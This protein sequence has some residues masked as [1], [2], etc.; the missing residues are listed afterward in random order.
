[1]FD[2]LR[3]KLSQGQMY[4]NTP[5]QEDECVITSAEPFTENLPAVELQSTTKEI[6]VSI[7]GVYGITKYKACHSC[8]KK[9][10][11]KKL[12]FCESCKLTLK[13]SKCTTNWFLR[14]YVELTSIPVQRFCLSLYN[15]A[16]IKLFKLSSN[17]YLCLCFLVGVWE[18]FHF[19]IE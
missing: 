16:A 17:R 9:V 1:M 5:K 14:I 13:A 6:V 10:S 8:S 4:L 11:V 19:I 15:D 7:Q 18:F 3:V 2:K 12:A